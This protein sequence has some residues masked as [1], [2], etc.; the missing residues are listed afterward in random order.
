MKNYIC[1]VLSGISNLTEA[2][3]LSKAGSILCYALVVMMP[4][5]SSEL[6]DCKIKLATCLLPGVTSFFLLFS[7]LFSYFS[8]DLSLCI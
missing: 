3:W 5:L 6:A 2:H 7:C 4:H 8:L 1:C